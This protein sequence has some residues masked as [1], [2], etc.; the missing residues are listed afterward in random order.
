MVKYQRCLYTEIEKTL[1]AKNC[2]LATY[3]F[4]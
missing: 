3:Y 4:R 2:K 1:V